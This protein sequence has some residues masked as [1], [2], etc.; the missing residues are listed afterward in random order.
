MANAEQIEIVSPSGQVQFY[1][2][3]PAIGIVNIGQHPDNDLVLEGPLVRPFH[4]LIDHRRRPYQYVS[5]E[6]DGA[7][8]TERT[9]G[10]WERLRIGEHELAL[11][12][13]NRPGQTM[14]PQNPSPS[15]APQQ[16]RPQAPMQP[17]TEIKTEWRARPG[18]TVRRNLTVQNGGDKAATF[19]ISAGGVPEEWLWLSQ[20]TI[21][22][23]PGGQAAVQLAVTPPPGPATQPG[24]YPLTW[25]MES[26]DYPGQVQNE[27]IYLEVEAVPSV[28]MS[29]PEPTAV[30]SRP[31][32]RAGH[33]YITVANWGNIPANIYLSGQERRNDCTVQIDP[34]LDRPAPE[35]GVEWERPQANGGFSPTG[36]LLLLPPGALAHLRVIIRPRTGRS[37]GIG[38][39]QHRFTVTAQST[40]STFPPQTSAG[41]FES[42]PAIHMGFLLLLAALLVL[43]ALYF[44]RSS[45]SADAGQTSTEPVVI[46]PSAMAARP[47]W[48]SPTSET[49]VRTMLA[50]GGP[51]GRQAGGL[52][53]SEMFQEIGELYGMDWR[54]LVAH[55]HRESRLDPNARGGSG[56]YGLMQILPSTWDE[57]AP[58]VQVSDPW[59]PYSNILVGAA[60]Y[61][62]IH[63]YFSDLGYADPQ[64]SLAA[65]NWGPERTLNLLDSGAGWFA[66]PLTQR[67]YVADILI[68]VENAPA[69][70]ADAEVRY[71]HTK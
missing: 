49:A 48:L 27:A 26:P 25:Q 51:R 56:E 15:Y 64:W 3:N 62:Y 4:A 50:T 57:W 18:Q 28:Q 63:S 68:S 10:E 13:G 14:S 2:L 44:S 53:Y 17:G 8:G 23:P 36:L 66:L 32:R 29:K 61:S 38:S 54:Q 7:V 46:D 35:E 52:T 6:E 5:L 34:V 11:M 69:L 60:Y 31:F 43:A 39:Q 24:V 45:T 1:E 22:L 41:T 30:I 21:P 70:A 37:F 40:D 67:M 59:D 20:Q 33:A 12:V 47:A 58:L 55:A 71:P 42:R 65:Y 19:V 16:N 9:L